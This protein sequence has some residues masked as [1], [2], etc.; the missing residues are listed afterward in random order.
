MKDNFSKEKSKATANIV[1][2]IFQY[3]EETGKIIKFQVVVNIS[4]EMVGSMLAIGKT[5][6]YTV[7]VF[8][9]GQTEGNMMGNISTIKNKD[10]EHTFGLMEEDMRANGKMENNMVMV[11]LL[12]LRGI[13][14]LVH[15]LMERGQDGL[16]S[17]KLL[18]FEITNTSNII[19]L[20]T[21]TPFFV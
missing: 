17:K 10:L 16:M 7:R 1:G 3:L 8:T 4:G 15:G 21:E 19:I 11:S 2:K 5:A 20:I 18:I 14:E 6:N 12:I 13:P 9:N